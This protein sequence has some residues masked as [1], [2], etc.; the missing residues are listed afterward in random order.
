MDGPGDVKLGERLR[1]QFKGSTLDLWDWGTAEDHTQ[2]IV[3]LPG[4]GV[5]PI[6]NPKDNEDRPKV[7][8][9]ASNIVEWTVVF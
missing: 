3:T 9:P 5:E 6:S 4:S 7:V 1:Y 2:T 8:I